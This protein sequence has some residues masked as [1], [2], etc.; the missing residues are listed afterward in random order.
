MNCEA[1]INQSGMSR[2]SIARTNVTSD[3]KQIQKHIE[4]FESEREEKN[5]F[6]KRLKPD[7]KSPAHTR[8]VYCYRS[9]K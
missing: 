3:S 2:I 7:R 4:K 9:E 6:T 1:G 8:N 5:E